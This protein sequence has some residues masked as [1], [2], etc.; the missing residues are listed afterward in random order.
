MYSGFKIINSYFLVYLFLPLLNHIFFMTDE[1][2][3]VYYIADIYSGKFFIFLILF[4]I[5]F[6]LMRVIFNL[7]KTNKIGKFERFF[8]DF[9]KI[10]NHNKVII[11]LFL[12]I[13]ILV[14]FDR[15]MSS[16]RY[17]GSISNLG[18][19]IY[20]I[21]IIKSFIQV[22]LL[23]LLFYIL[24]RKNII[25]IKTKVSLFFLLYAWMYSASGVGDIFIG[26]IFFLV[27]LFPK[28][29]SDVMTNNEESKSI[30]SSFIKN[31]YTFIFFIV[32]LYAALIFGES[33]K[34]G[35][36][37]YLLIEAV[38]FNPFW[39]YERM[40]EGVSSHYYSI[41]QFF[42][43]YAQNRLLDYK[44]P[45]SYPLETFLYRLSLIMGFDE[46]SRPLLSSISHLNF[47]VLSDYQSAIAGTSPGP[48]ASFLFLFS[49]PLAMFVS[50]FY[51]AL[52]IKI[53]DNFFCFKNKSLTLIGSLIILNQVIGLLQS[54]IDF[55]L[56]F[57]GGFT[58]FFIFVLFSL[59]NKSYYKLNF[60]PQ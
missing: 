47:M 16:Y 36:G 33:I 9:Y 58:F 10:I 32:V 28:I 42:D 19:N 43:G 14:L 38:E 13:L 31:I 29:M 8:S 46:V 6:I 7:P 27:L 22:M 52:T 49:S 51:L 20:I 3:T 39:L 21:M 60:K 57:D 25:G 45:I 2:F 5:F 30:F 55:L 17:S 11:S 50:L 48:V 18:S 44:N 15:N 24:D 37:F 35:T 1:H 41:I 4:F 53:I 56:I 34:G 12:L 26:G 59:A 54:P 23:W 40:V